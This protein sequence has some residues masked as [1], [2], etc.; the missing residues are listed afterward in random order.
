MVRFQIGRCPKLKQSSWNFLHFIDI[1][2]DHPG[3]L[4]FQIVP[5]VN[6]NQ[7][8]HFSLDFR[9]IFLCRCWLFL[10]GAKLAGY[11]STPDCLFEIS[12]GMA[13]HICYQT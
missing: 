4:I 6:K 3:K 9:H 1:L 11:K 7:Y 8:A 13:T 12:N 5:D 10:F 2:N